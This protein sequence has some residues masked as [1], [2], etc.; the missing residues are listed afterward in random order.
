MATQALGA[1]HQVAKAR[2]YGHDLA[3]LRAQVT[4]ST[5]L[6]FIANPNNP[7]GTWLPSG[8]LEAFIADLPRRV[9]V[10]VDEAYFDYVEEP[11]FP[12]CSKWIGR[13]PNL[14]V[15][16]TFSKVHALAGLR[17]GYAVS[18]PDV[19]AMLNRVRDPFNVNSLGLVGAQA[20]LDDREHI[21]RSVALNRTGLVTL[22][23][24]CAELGLGHIPSVGNFLTVDFAKPAGPIYQALLREG[25]ILRPIAG[26]GLPNHLRITVGTATEN[27]RCIAALRKVL[28][29]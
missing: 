22:R 19:A 9:L 2:D 1:Q 23:E 12:D 6:V 11:D 20:A 21:R 28:K 15:T 3:A 24:A 16:R 14:I 27:A 8:A 7:T 25:V 26:Y 17:V 13:Y 5:R 10:V 29:G 18:S 4:T